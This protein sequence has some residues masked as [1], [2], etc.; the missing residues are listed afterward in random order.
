M[1]LIK[2][3]SFRKCATLVFIFLTV[4][5]GFWPVVSV[6]CEQN[7]RVFALKEI[8]STSIDTQYGGRRL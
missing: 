7:A 2:F 4:Y 8:D 5:N 3:L 1:P 6:L